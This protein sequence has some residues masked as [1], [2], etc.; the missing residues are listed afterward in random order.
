MPTW[1]DSFETEERHLVKMR[2]SESIHFESFFVLNLF[3]RSLAPV[4]ACEAVLR[5]FNRN[6]RGP[7]SGWSDKC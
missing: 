2:Q 7:W 5:P 4:D 3:A 1:P 6:R